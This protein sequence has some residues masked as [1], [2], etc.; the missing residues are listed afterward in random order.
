MTTDWG[1]WH[2]EYAD[3]GSALSARLVAVRGVIASWLEETAPRPVRVVSACA[4]DGRDLL[5][6]LAGRSL[7]GHSDVARVAATLVEFDPGLGRVALREAERVGLED[8]EVRCTDAGST[9]AYAGVGPADLLLLCGVFGNV[10]DE[11]VHRTLRALPQLCAPGALVVWTRHRGEPDLTPRIRQWF[12]DLDCE[13][14]EFISP[15]P[16]AWAVGAHRFVG[17][18]QDLARDDRLFTFIR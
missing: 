8:V 7:A 17:R 1:A 14:Q 18:P 3:P 2:E 6:A 10:T 4:G 15:G 12:A 13:E 9:R 5:G 16:G 11:D